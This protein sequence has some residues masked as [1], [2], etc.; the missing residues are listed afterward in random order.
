MPLLRSTPRPPRRPRGHA[1]ALA[2]TMAL[3][4]ALCGPVLSLARG[5]LGHPRPAPPPPAFDRPGPWTDGLRVPDTIQA[6]AIDAL[7]GIVLAVAILVLAGAAVNAATLLLS[8][9]AARRHETAMRAV[10][11]ATP[12]RLARRALAEGALLGLAGGGA[13]LL[14][15]LAGG[16]AARGA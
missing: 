4:V 2:A 16:T 14:L 1:P 7:V 12:G 6:N 10:L 3:G 13:G 8:R 5:R 15:A 11:G 9:A